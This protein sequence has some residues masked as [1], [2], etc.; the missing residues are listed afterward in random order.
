VWKEKE[1]RGRYKGPEEN[2]NSELARGGE[3]GQRK[4]KEEKNGKN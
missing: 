3:D 2:I 1:K 4:E